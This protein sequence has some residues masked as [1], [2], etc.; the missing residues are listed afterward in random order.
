MSGQYWRPSYF[1][2]RVNFTVFPPL[3]PHRDL[4]VNLIRSHASGVGEPLSPQKTR[5]LL[6]LRINVLAKGCSGI[7]PKIVYQMIDAFN[8]KRAVVSLQA[9]V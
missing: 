4:Q 8:S 1:F 9:T 3:F 2:S 7:S 6:A 5:M